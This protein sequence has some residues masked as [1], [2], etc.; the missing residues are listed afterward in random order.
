MDGL[1]E[2]KNKVPKRERSQ[3]IMNMLS[4]HFHYPQGVTIEE[5]CE[6][7]GVRKSSVNAMIRELREDGEEIKVHKGQ[8]SI[9][10]D[11]EASIMA[12]IVLSS[13]SH[14]E[15]STNKESIFKML[16]LCCVIAGYQEISRI[17]DMMN[18]LLPHTKGVSESMIRDHLQS[19]TASG[20]LIQRTYGI[21][22]K[23]I[24]KY[25]YELGAEA[26]Y[27]FPVAYYGIRKH[28]QIHP[29]ILSLIN[30]YEYNAGSY[31]QN[32]YRISR[33]LNYQ[34][35]GTI[36]YSLDHSLL[37]KGHHHDE[38][39]NHAHITEKLGTC[40]YQH[41]AIRIS[42]L[43]RTGN[44]IEQEDVKIG[45]IAY[46]E[47]KD[48]LYLMCEALS[49]ARSS[50][51]IRKMIRMVSL[52]S[53]EELPEE[54]DI[55]QSDEY[56]RIFDEMYDCSY[57]RPIEV[58]VLIADYGNVGDKFSRQVWL[59]NHNLSGKAIARLEEL[60]EDE[61]LRVKDWLNSI[62][63]EKL[64]ELDIKWRYVDT[65]RGLDDFVA[66]LRGYGRSCILY[67]PQELRNKAGN[68]ALHTKRHYE[69]AKAQ[70][71]EMAAS[72]T[73]MIPRTSNPSMVH[74]TY[75]N[76]R[77]EKDAVIRLTQIMALLVNA[78]YYR[79]SLD[80][81]KTSDQRGKQF[82]ITSGEIAEI[83]GCNENVIR[84]DLY[85]MYHLYT[86]YSR[87][88]Q[89]EG[90]TGTRMVQQDTI[91]TEE[92][93]YLGLLIY[94]KMDDHGEKQLVEVHEPNWDTVHDS[95]YDPEEDQDYLFITRPELDHRMELFLEKGD[96]TL[97]FGID[98]SF[99]NGT[100][101]LVLDAVEYQCLRGIL[102][103]H[104][105]KKYLQI[106]HI[107]QVKYLWPQKQ[108]RPY[109]NKRYHAISQELNLLSRKIQNAI[110]KNAY[111]SFRYRS[112][113]SGAAEAKKL[114][115]LPR[116]MFYDENSK[117]Y[118]V[119]SIDIRPKNAPRYSVYRLD[120]ILP[121]TVKVIDKNEQTEDPAM[122][123]QAEVMIRNLSYMW[124][125]ETDY[126][127]YDVE[128]IVDDVNHGNVIRNVLWD[129]QPY[130]DHAGYQIEQLP[131]DTGI[132]VT[133]KVMGLKAFIR[134]LRSYGSAI[135][136]LK[137]Q[138]AAEHVYTSNE[139]RW[140]LYQR[141]GEEDIL[142]KDI[143]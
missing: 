46:S 45:F 47:R 19:M 89:E 74:L 101:L 54:N 6:A 131:D 1:V 119:I 137:P 140:K 30:E 72:G 136:L 36:W 63:D 49:S 17:Y 53:A 91:D 40:D 84:H 43:S 38:S 10:S 141:L 113:K 105:E 56:K 122:L 52:K 73:E 18:R 51:P 59:R 24:I 104:G 143:L 103:E 99:F 15:I 132:R 92:M 94:Q 69:R 60:S 85:E 125:I 106:K 62:A 139:A 57:S 138:E 117:M 109:W 83:L 76:Y 7:L 25:Y 77:S 133:G 96:E 64:Q 78:E 120:R 124:G 80:N 75:T 121:D 95:L 5:M 81:R 50:K 90:Y 44:L 110:R 82:H 86:E 31:D 87:E 13:S 112:R 28:Y 129:L 48:E 88:L 70:S 116:K 14:R 16:I 128:F 100:E 134:W 135:V 35:Q 61:R 32:L 114:E 118:Y 27:F 68:S 12:P 29:S 22:E 115:M 41:K 93:T 26:P 142:Q 67:S 102:R 11:R 39:M 65:I 33:K 20:L 130:V 21:E 111:L 42:Y 123:E 8:Y 97:S 126:N 107:D 55:Y 3:V 9:E 98:Y 127:L 37:L 34:V 66:D 23:K 108:E 58:E 2:K 4:D 79:E 71:E